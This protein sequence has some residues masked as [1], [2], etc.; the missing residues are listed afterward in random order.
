[1]AEGGLDPENIA[2]LAP[3]ADFFAVGEEI[4]NDD[5]P[6]AALKRL[7]AAMIPG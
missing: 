1:V 6:L 4:W 5:D 7:Q 3:F 2:T